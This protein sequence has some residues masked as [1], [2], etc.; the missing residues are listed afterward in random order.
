MWEINKEKIIKVVI[1]AVIIIAF[2]V[3]L[4]LVDESERRAEY[5]TG[6]YWVAKDYHHVYE[7]YSGEIVDYIEENEKCKIDGDT[8]IVTSTDKGL[9]A[10]GIM[11]CV[12]FGI[13]IMCTVCYIVADVYYASKNN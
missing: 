1:W 6:E 3:G 8:I 11:L 12:I 2:I 10:V 4:I 9:Y 7:T 13:P 5:S